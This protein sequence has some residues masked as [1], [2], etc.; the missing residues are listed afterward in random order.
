MEFLGTKFSI[1]LGAWRLRFAFV[2]EEACDEVPPQ[3]KRVHHVT[4]PQS[5]DRAVRR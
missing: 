5:A 3:G 1:T 4:V 2:L